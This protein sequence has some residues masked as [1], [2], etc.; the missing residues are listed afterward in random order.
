MLYGAIFGDIAGSL[1]EF[2]A[3]KGN[4]FTLVPNGS[5]F[6]DDTIMTLAVANWLL[7]DEN[8]SDDQLV[9]EMQLFG[10][11]YP[12][13]GY[14]GMFRKWLVS[15][16]PQPYNS[17]GNGSA[18]RVSPCGWISNDINEILSIARQSAEVTHNHPEGIKGAQ[19]IAMAIWIARTINEKPQH[20][21]ESIKKAIKKVISDCYGYNLN[22]TID[23]IIESGYRFNETCQGSVPEAIIAV[24]EST[25]FESAIRN[26]IRLRGDADTQACI[27]G[28]IAEV[29]YGIPEEFKQVVKDKLDPFLLNIVEEFNKKYE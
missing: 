19:A 14:G 3:A 10:K 20:S 6:T 23:G 21:P 27:A 18:M 4:D 16:D 13:G 1:Y 5:R 22:R 15:S 28:A 25:D 9:K 11:K 7:T 29:M 12:R 24:L 2:N 17:F 26:A 8:L